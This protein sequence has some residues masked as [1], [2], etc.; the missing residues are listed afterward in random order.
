M[1][2]FQKIG[3]NWMSKFNYRL[4]AT[5]NHIDEMIQ[6]FSNLIKILSLIPDLSMQQCSNF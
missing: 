3:I 5:Q 1:L 4:T 2:H 6:I